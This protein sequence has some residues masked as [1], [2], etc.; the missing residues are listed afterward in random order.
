MNTNISVDYDSG[1][2]IIGDTYHYKFKFNNGSYSAHA[3]FCKWDE[4]GYRND[5]AAIKG[6]KKHF[7]QYINKNSAKFANII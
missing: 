1:I 5:L 3:M 4:Y 2:V 6:I 7:K